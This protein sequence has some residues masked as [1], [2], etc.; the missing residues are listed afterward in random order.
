MDSQGILT[1]TE[2]AHEAVAFGVRWLDEKYPGWWDWI[3]LE[4]L[5]M[6]SSSCCV[7]AQIE[8][9]L[10]T[11]TDGYICD[12]QQFYV[13]FVEDRHS[14]PFGDRKILGFVGEYQ[15][16][17]DAWKSIILVRQLWFQGQVDIVPN[18]LSTGAATIQPI[19]KP[20]RA[21]WWPWR[22]N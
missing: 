2:R 19:H 10:S 12:P 11:A 15:Y 7:A 22:W 1:E 4:R 20:S 9:K 5:D 16:L 3:D 21:R 13:R 6:W 14:M 18:D 17:Q 8:H